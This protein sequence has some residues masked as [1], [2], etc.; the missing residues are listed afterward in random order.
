LPSV[1]GIV[2]LFRASCSK[3]F[4]TNFPVDGSGFF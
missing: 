3:R 4:A 2:L 1:F